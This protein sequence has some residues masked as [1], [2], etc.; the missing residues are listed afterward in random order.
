MYGWW[1]RNVSHFYWRAYGGELFAR[2]WFGKLAHRKPLTGF[3]AGIYAQYYMYDFELGG[4]GEMAGKP[5]DNLWNQGMYG[6][7]VEFGFSFPIKKRLNIDLTLG[8]GYSGGEYHKYIP[9]D[10]HYVWQ[11]TYRRNYVG[12][13]KAEVALVWLIGPGNTNE[14]P[15]TQ[16][17]K[18]KEVPND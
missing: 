11:G 9:I 3:H 16:N 10:T 15:K 1:S 2:W 5:E 18:R 14:K 8:I 17:A 4:K 13:T 6:G 7:S 12:P